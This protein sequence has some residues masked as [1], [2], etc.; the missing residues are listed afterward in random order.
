MRIVTFK[1]LKS[2]LDLNVT[3]LTDQPWSEGSDPLWLFR[4]EP[5]MSPLPPKTH[6]SRQQQQHNRKKQ[7]NQKSST[8]PFQHLQLSS[9]AP[10]LQRFGSQLI[11]PPRRPISLAQL[12]WQRCSAGS[13]RKTGLVSQ[14]SAAK[15]PRRWSVG[16]LM[17]GGAGG[18]DPFYK[19]K[20]C[21]GQ[22]RRN[23]SVVME[24]GFWLRWM[25]V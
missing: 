12:S 21:S 18:S 11:T 9:E 25:F 2:D 6:H 23:G 8:A 7:H 15:A 1:M 17:L 4:E 3:N 19:H 14:V 5:G 20:L 16:A 13:P 10:D 22:L 24:V